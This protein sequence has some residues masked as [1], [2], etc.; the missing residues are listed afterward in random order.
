MHEKVELLTGRPRISV[1]HLERSHI[2]VLNAHSGAQGRQLLG[3]AEAAVSSIATT[4]GM[5]KRIL[6]CSLGFLGVA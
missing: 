2:S 3:R 1:K 4:E 6:E 5:E